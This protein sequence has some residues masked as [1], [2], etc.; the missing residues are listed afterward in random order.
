MLTMAQ[1]AKPDDPQAHRVHVVLDDA[2]QHRNVADTGRCCRCG[3]LWPCADVRY[4]A[5]LW[6]AWRQERGA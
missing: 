3:E 5:R 6:Q 2:A 4:A 1:D